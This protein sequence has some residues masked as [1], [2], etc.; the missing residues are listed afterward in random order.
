MGRCGRK[1]RCD[2][3]ECAAMTESLRMSI[4]V[5][6]VP[7]E[8]A[9]AGRYIIELVRAL[10]QCDNEDHLEL[11]LIARKGDSD[12]WTDTNPTA[13]VHAWAPTSRPLRLLWE[14]AVLGY[15]LQRLGVLVHHGPHY[16]MPRLPGPRLPGP[17]LQGPR[18]PGPRVPGHGNPGRTGIR[19]K[20]LVT[21]HDMTFFSHSQLH[22][23]TKSFV[24]RRAIVKAAACA[25][26]TV[27]VSDFTAR[28][29]R[30]RL[31]PWHLVAVAPHGVDHQRFSPLSAD[32]DADAARLVQ[33]GVRAPF[34]CFV[35]T[36][37][38]R[39]DIVGLI[40]AFERLAR[41]HPSL[42]LVI[43][44][45][46]GWHTEL[47]TAA[48]AASPFSDRIRRVG[49]VHDDDV[50]ALYRGAAVVTYP[51]H[52]EGFGLPVLEALAC[53][54]AVVTTSG[55]V[56]AEIA[57]DAALLVTRGSVTDLAAALDAAQGTEGDACR[58]RGPKVAAAYTWQACAA[59]HL[60]L[61]RQ[62]AS[63]S[64]PTT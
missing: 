57:G 21:I 6:A 60:R 13:I 31:H 32:A 15:K 18:V 50:A 52:E 56:M 37:E 22:E 17:R 38:P 28:Q 23:R 46:D 63:G 10:G 51:S 24:F 45:Q 41:G 61:Y 27:C 3:Q 39:K 11:H 7:P 20:R 43:A 53:G 47:V 19:F 35:G 64:E 33:L 42:S 5:S 58:A 48:I 40:A 9:G 54:A 12:R 25:D 36:I 4:D 55:T 1:T 14:Q 16:T 26:A 8:P 34:V 30:E 44:G 29:F 2:L 49:Y 59:Q 62:L